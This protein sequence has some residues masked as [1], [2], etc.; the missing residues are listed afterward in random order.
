M[1]FVQDIEIHATADDYENAYAFFEKVAAPTL[2]Y[3]TW[4]P[5]GDFYQRT[6]ETIRL[7]TGGFN[8]EDLEESIGRI[9][10]DLPMHASDEEYDALSVIARY[11][12]WLASDASAGITEEQVREEAELFMERARDNAIL[13]ESRSFESIIPWLLGL[14]EQDGFRFES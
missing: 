13:S 3:C 4:L 12:S 2:Y 14:A 7:R 5:P 1:R 9:R 11:A 6:A 8:L 10:N